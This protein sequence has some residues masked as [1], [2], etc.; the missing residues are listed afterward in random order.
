[1]GEL[2]FCAYKAAV[3]QGKR[4]IHKI[5]IPYLTN[6]YRLFIMSFVG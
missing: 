5:F 2:L 3:S 6:R 1:M 4:Q